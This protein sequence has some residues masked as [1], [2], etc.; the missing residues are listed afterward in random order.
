MAGRALPSGQP[1]KPR[2]QQQ[3]PLP[4]SP[5]AAPAQARAPIRQAWRAGDKVLWQGYNGTFLRETIDGQVEVLIGTRTCRVPR[6]ELQPT[7]YRVIAYN[8]VTGRGGDIINIP[9]ALLP[10]VFTIARL[11]KATVSAPGEAAL[12]R[13]QT[14]ELAAIL[15][16]RPDARFR[17][18]LE[19]VP[20]T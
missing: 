2:Q 1:R 14:R 15:G 17:Y 16:F 9:T 10:Q 20:A 12:D 19:A 6:D 7:R 8:R 18:H 13:N 5:P 4:S 11:A 3:R